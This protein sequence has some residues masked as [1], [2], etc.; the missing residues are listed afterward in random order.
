MNWLTR[1]KTRVSSRRE[2][3]GGARCDVHDDFIGG[4]FVADRVRG[5]RGDGAQLPLQR[6]VGHGVQRGPVPTH[7]GRT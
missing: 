6:P 5:L 3:E 7:L 2:D 4:Q 1:R